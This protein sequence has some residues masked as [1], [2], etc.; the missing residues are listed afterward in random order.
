MFED[1]KF[2]MCAPADSSMAVTRQWWRQIDAHGFDFIGLAD[3]PL[4]CREV[5]VSLAAA[6]MDTSR[7][8]LML[9]V[10]NPITRDVSV[11]AGAMQGLREIAGDRLWYGFGAGDS[12]ILGVG[13]KHATGSQMADYL[14]ALREILAG[15]TADYNGRKITAAWR[16]WKPWRPH[17]MMAAG[18]EKNLRMAARVADSVIT[19]LGLLPDQVARSIELVQEGAR[20][21]GRDPSE[22]DI[23]YLVTVVPGESVEAAFANYNAA[24]QAKRFVET[25]EKD[26]EK[27]PPEVRAALREMAPYY[28]LQKH[29]RTN[30]EVADVAIRTGTLDW[31]VQ[32]AGGMFGDQ[33]YTDAVERLRQMGAKNLI[34]VGMSPDKPAIIDAVAA[35]TVAKRKALAPSG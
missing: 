12:S 8:K 6:A 13:L 35:A 31:F 3:T 33:N 29:S 10:S 14:V 9:M 15:R 5:Y 18:G 23:W 19:S 21:A 4:L 20:E 16:D 34:L 11:T 7:A 2:C 27:Y 30:Q 24:A 26:A 25:G 1:M 32:R 28:S 22:V 17:L